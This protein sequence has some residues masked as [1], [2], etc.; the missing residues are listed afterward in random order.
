MAA[1][2][3]GSRGSDSLPRRREALNYVVTSVILN[4]HMTHLDPRTYTYLHKGI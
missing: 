4:S 1:K 3:V 2:G